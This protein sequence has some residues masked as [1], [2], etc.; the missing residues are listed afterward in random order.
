MHL[1]SAPQALNSREARTEN[2]GN[3]G[4]YGDFGNLPAGSHSLFN[5]EQPVAGL[6][7]TFITVITG[8]VFP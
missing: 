1:M 5:P 6:S 4:N 8:K 3:F 2:Y 7:I